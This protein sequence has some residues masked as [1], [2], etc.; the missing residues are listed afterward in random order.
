MSYLFVS[1]DLHVVRLLCD[2]VI[3]MKAGRIVEEGTAAEVL[4]SP[5]GRLYARAD[6]RDPAP[7]GVGSRHWPTIEIPCPPF[8]PPQALTLDAETLARSIDGSALGLQRLAIAPEWRAGVTAHL[9]RPPPPPTSCSPFRCRTKSEPAPV[10][11][12]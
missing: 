5:E 9:R 12:A 3:V 2:R 8:H 6:R 7:A 1:H 4:E 11:A 10:F